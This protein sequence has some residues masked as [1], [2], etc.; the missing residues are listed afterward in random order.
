MKFDELFYLSSFDVVKNE[1]VLNEIENVFFFDKRQNDK[2]M[3]F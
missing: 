3:D 2:L 1:N